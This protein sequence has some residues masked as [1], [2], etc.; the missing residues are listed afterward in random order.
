MLRFWAKKSM[1]T[2]FLS[3]KKKNYPFG[4]SIL[5][6]LDRLQVHVSQQNNVEHWDQC[7]FWTTICQRLIIYSYSPYVNLASKILISRAK[8]EL[9]KKIDNFQLCELCGRLVYSR[10][11]ADHRAVC[12]ADLSN[13]DHKCAFTQDG[14][15]HALVVEKNNEI[16]QVR[17]IDLSKG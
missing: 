15:L 2:F 14:V 7:W 1:I 13:E 12:G 3:F 4:L 6:Y 5:L 16:F 8:D 10:Q 11:L 17:Q 9:E